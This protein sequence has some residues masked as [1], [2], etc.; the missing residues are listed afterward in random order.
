MYASQ[1][2]NIGRVLAGR[3]QE[4]IL[5]AHVDVYADPEKRMGTADE[6]MGRVE[7]CL[8]DL[9]TDSIELFQFHAVMDEETADFIRTGGA[10][11]GLKRAQEQGKVQHIGITGHYSPALVYALKSDEYDT[12]M[13]PFNVMRRDFGEDP[14][15][16]LFPFARR[17]DIGVIIMKPIASGR[18]T[19]NL[20]A[21]LK[22]ILAHEVALT[23]PGAGNTRQLDANIDIVEEFTALSEQ[24]RKAC[25]EELSFL[26]EPYC[27]QCRYCL[28]CP[29]E[30]DIP[31]ILR[32]GRTCS[33]FGLTEWIR[34]EEVGALEVHPERCD[35]CHF[36]ES[37]CPYDLPVR[38][39]IREAQQYSQQV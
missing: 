36:C 3:R 26:G 2:E 39:M 25:T 20:P 1:E 29:G 15:Y 8:R 28:P 34:A 35:S 23:I 6:I 7:T 10:L 30:M 31:A 12:V 32:M 14:S 13:V 27:R 9:Q 21:A 19:Q 37:R 17:M 5:A 33:F 11:E 38:Q 4:F 22:F 16:G 18:I 24:E